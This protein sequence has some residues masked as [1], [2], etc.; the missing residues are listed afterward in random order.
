M[1]Y[2]QNNK[3]TPEKAYTYARNSPTKKK[4]SEENDKDI[5]LVYSIAEQIKKTRGLASI[6][7]VEIIKEFFD[8]YKSGKSLEYMKDFSSMLDLLLNKNNPDNINIIY[9]WRVDRFGRN[10]K[11]M[12]DAVKRLTEKEIYIKFVDGGFDTFSSIGRML[13]GILSS[14]AEWQR[15]EIVTNTSIGRE[16]EHLLHPEKFGRPKKEIDWKKVSN[17]LNVK[18]KEI[19]KYSYS[20]SEIARTLKISPATLIRRYRN[21]VGQLPMRKI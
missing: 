8:E 20:W 21:E 3:F 13:M 18:D 2:K 5:S 9:C 17:F 14:F 11:D 16:R 1:G 6:D 7:N 12:L 19:D 4:K 10:Q 15:E